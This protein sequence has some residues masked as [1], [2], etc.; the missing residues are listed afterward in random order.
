VIPEA[1]IEIFDKKKSIFADYQFPL[2]NL[3]ET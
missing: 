2:P 1:E 3:S